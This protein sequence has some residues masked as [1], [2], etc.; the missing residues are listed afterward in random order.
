MRPRKL[1]QFMLMQQHETHAQWQQQLQ[2]TQLMVGKTSNTS[3]IESA[4][5]RARTNL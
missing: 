2:Q 4:E 3:K 1:Q 5:R